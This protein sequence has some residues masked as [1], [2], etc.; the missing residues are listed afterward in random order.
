M[1]SISGSQ[2]Q[3]AVLEMSLSVGGYS[4]FR[5]AKESVGSLGGFLPLDFTD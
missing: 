3:V 4:G 1:G 5:Q 2:S